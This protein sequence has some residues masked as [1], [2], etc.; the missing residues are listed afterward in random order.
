MP[1]DLEALFRP[2]S[3]A[4]F[5]A[6]RNPEK[7][8]HRLLK[9]LLDYGF[10]GRVYP[11]NPSREA[12]LGRPSATTIREIPEPIDLALVSIPQ[13]KVLDAMKACADAGVRAAVILT[14]GFGETGQGGAEKEAAIRALARSSGMRV[15]GPNCMGILNLHHALN[16]T[17]FWEVPREIGGVSFI[18]QSGAYGGIFFDQVRSRPIGVSKFVS[19]GNQ[20]DLTHAELVEYLAGDPETDLIAL[21]IEE[22]GDGQ[23]FLRASRAAAN[24][25]PVVAMKAGRTGAGTR[26]AISHTGS[27]AGTAAVYEAAFRRAGM[28]QARETEAFFDAIEVLSTSRYLPRDG[29]LAILTIS[30]GPGVVA[31]DAA[32]EAGLEVPPLGELTR[33]RIQDLAPPFGATRN[34]VDLTPQM[35]ARH[36]AACVDAVVGAEEISG[37][38]TI[39]VGLDVPEYG[40]AIVAAAGAHGKPV[41][42]FTLDTPRVDDILRR[43]GIPL[44]ASPERAVRAYGVL[45]GYGRTVAG[46]GERRPEVRRVMGPVS[47]GGVR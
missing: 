35:E 26:A 17:Y 2:R 16:A 22:I 39:N 8:G 29:R 40:Q 11:I 38:V 9:N 18:S 13:E 42:A 1:R 23:A 3:V 44:L 10:Q 21:F 31:A 45:V 15:L 33:R 47:R 30:G 19:L 6:S 24:A 4:I 32:E 34:P 14:S 41:V 25:K 7:L 5:G 43:A 20:L 46:E 27:L 37:V 36:F 28:V 12:I